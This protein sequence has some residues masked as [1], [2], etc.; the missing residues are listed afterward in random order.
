M[1]DFQYQL[2]DLGR[3]R[4]RRYSQHCTYFGAA[5]VSLQDYIASVHAQSLTNQHPTAERPAPGL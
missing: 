1:N 5:P 3:E 4:G 2:S